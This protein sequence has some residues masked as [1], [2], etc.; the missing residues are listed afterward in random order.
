[1]ILLS[2]RSHQF[3]VKTGVTLYLYTA[4]VK[5]DGDLPLIELKFIYTWFTRTQIN[6][7]LKFGDE[8]YI[9][10]VHTDIQ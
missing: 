7:M 2:P 4:C 1:M 10:Y 8:I 5:F 9:L 6:F 3:L